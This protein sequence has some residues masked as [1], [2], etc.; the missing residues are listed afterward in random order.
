MY[1][2]LQ[3]TLYCMNTTFY[4]EHNPLHHSRTLQWDDRTFHVFISSRRDLPEPQVVKQE[5]ACIIINKHRTYPDGCMFDRLPASES[6]SAVYPC[7]LLWNHTILLG[8]NFAQINL[9]RSYAVFKELLVVWKYDTHISYFFPPTSAFAWYQR[10]RT[11][12]SN[13]NSCK[14]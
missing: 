13:F 12:N 14:P 7:G 11:S 9:L 3:E 10:F 2:L 6:V 1:T 4:C 8:I 5:C